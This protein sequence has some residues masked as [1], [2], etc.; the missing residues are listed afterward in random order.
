MRQAARLAPT[1]LAGD[2]E[3][4]RQVNAAYAEALEAKN[5]PE[6]AG[7]A[8]GCRRLLA[9]PTGRELEANPA[10]TDTCNQLCQ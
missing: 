3:R 1:P 8:A 5:M 9:A 10:Q 7:G 4:Q 6:D 2:E